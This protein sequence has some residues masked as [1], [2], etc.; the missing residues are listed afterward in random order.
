LAAVGGFFGNI[1]DRATYDTRTVWANTDTPDYS[2]AGRIYVTA[3]TTIGSLVGVTQLSDAFSQNA[4]VDGHLQSIGERAFKG[5]T[6]GIQL[7]S[8]GFSLGSAVSKA[9]GL[10]GGMRSAPNSASPRYR[11]V[12]NDGT[13]VVDGQQPPRLSMSPD[14]TAAGPH[15][16]IRYD[17]VNG[18]I[19]QLREFDGA[20]TPVR[21]IDF[22]NPT[23]PNGTPRPG[24]AGPP[25]Q[26]PF[27]INDPRVGPKSG[28]KRGGPEPI[29]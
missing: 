7:A 15:S 1:W 8:A 28:L 26:H 20:G 23:F 3:G 6:G 13:L 22:T 10:A 19:Y 29:N 14:P 24:H 9:A 21:D 17:D 18:R 4:A 11:S 5:V 16:R 27:N 2:L 25:H 12:Y